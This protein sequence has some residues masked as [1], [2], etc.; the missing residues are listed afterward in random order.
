MSDTP[1]DRL[2]ANPDSP[3]YDAEA[4]ERGVG[5]RFKGVEKTNVDEYCVSEGWVRVT[6]G[7]TVDRK[8]NAM[9]IKLQGEVVPYFRDAETSAE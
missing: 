8:G 2:S 3:Y 6:A 4:L 7:K 9:T 5:I 1:P